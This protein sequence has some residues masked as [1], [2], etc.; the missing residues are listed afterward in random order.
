MPV[1]KV[2]FG[3]LLA[4]AAFVLLMIGAV[5]PTAKL[6]IA[7]VAGVLFMPVVMHSGRG[8]ALLAFAATALLALLLLPNKSCGLYFAALLGWYPIAKNLFESS[9]NRVVEWTA[10][11]L[12]ANAALAVAVLFFQALALPEGFL[13]RV[14]GWLIVVAVLAY[15]AVFVVYDFGLNRLAGL[16]AGLLPK[17]R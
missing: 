12:A 8:A 1:R 15:N 17:G 13:D 2:A 4:A 16:L 11:L 3:G 5:S 10:K 14:T 6:A 9:K 7:A